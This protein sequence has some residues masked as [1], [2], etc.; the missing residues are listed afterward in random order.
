MTRDPVPEFKPQYSRFPLFH[1]HAESDGS[2]RHGVPEYRCY[3]F[4][5]TQALEEP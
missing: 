5:G 2:H 1:P 4:A 3:P